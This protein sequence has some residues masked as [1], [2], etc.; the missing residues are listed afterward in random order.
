MSIKLSDIKPLRAVLGSNSPEASEE[1]LVHINYSALDMDPVEKEIIEYLN[2]CYNDSANLPSIDYV[3]Q[4]F[5]SLGR[6]PVA[7][8]VEQLKK[9]N[10][11]TLVDLKLY[12]KEYSAEKKAKLFDTVFKTAQSISKL[13]ETVEGKYRKGWAEALLFIE[14]NM[15]KFEDE[16][17]FSAQQSGELGEDALLGWDRYMERKATPASQR[18][19]LSGLNVIDNSVF[20][21]KP[22][23][24][25]LALGFTSSG[26]TLFSINYI[27]HAVVNLGKNAVMFSLEMSKEEI[28]NILYAR[29]SAH[30]KFKPI[31]API[32]ITDFKN[33]LLNA[34]AEDFMR[35]C[36]LQ[37]L[38]TNEQHGKLIIEYPGESFSMSAL[39]KK[40]NKIQKKTDIDMIVLDYPEL[41]EPDPGQGGKDYTTTL[42]RIMKQIKQLAMTFRDGRG[43]FVLC[44]FQAN[45]D[46]YERAKKAGGIYDLRAL[47][48]ANEAERTA[49][50]VYSIF[51]DL[52]ARDQEMNITGIKHRGGALFGPEKVGV[53]WE[54]GYVAN[55]EVDTELDMTGFIFDDD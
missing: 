17:D 16:D 31:H 36:V 54:S 34:E 37:D 5:Y 4:H 23:Q 51:R 22:K 2:D 13:G 46:G 25:H 38:Y 6:T 27:Y 48:Y 30:P 9:G 8:Y 53:M 18:G 15:S 24:V 43:L 12:L 41:M 47:S 11:L 44:P 40:L 33:G 35:N 55:M 10:D 32:K 49:D 19:I 7:D 50:I 26:K 1:A 20:G 52:E 3:Y 39:K 42:N 45:R 14:E 29:H 21:A 28:E